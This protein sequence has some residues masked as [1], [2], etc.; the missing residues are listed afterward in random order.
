MKT[1]V[2][3]VTVSAKEHKHNYYEII[4]YREGEGNFHYSK[5]SLPIS[6]GKFVIV[7]PETVHAS[8]YLDTAE[9]IYIKGDFKHIFSLSSPTE[10]F[11]DDEKS[12]AFLAEMMLKNK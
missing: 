7:P 11:D 9:T 2:G 8:K 5:K 10:V 4:F 1:S 3:F 12:G 6:P